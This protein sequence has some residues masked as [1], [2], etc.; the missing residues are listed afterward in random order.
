M[1]ILLTTLKALLTGIILAAIYVGW[2]YWTDQAIRAQLNAIIG[3][4]L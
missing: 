3:I 4:E 2:S 1:K